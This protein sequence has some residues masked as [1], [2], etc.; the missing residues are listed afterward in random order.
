MSGAFYK[1]I[2]G[3]NYKKSFELSDITYPRTRTFTKILGR[4]C[5][6]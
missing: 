3:V 6:L 5:V 2:I 4:L 1:F